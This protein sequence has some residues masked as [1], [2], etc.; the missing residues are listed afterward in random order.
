MPLILVLTSCGGNQSN[1]GNNAGNSANVST[2]NASSAPSQELAQNVTT[3]VMQVPNPWVFFPNTLKLENKAYAGNAEI[4]FSTFVNVSSLPKGAIGK[5]M[6]VVYSTLLEA[7]TAISYLQK[8]YGYAGTIVELYQTFIN[9]NPNNYKTFEKTTDNFTFKIV[10]DDQ[11]YK[12]YVSYQSVAIE[13][14]YEITTAKCYGRIQLTN[15]NV[16]KYE[17]SNNKLTIAVNIFNVSLNELHFERNGN[18]ITGYL[19]EFLGTE[20]HNLKTSAFIKIDEN[21]TT[22]ISN[23]RETDDLLI[24]GYMEVYKNSTGNL[25][26]AE[27]KETVKGADYDTK[28]FNLWDVSN[29]NTIKVLDDVNGLNADTIFI[30]GSDTAIKTKLVGGLSL[31]ATSRR[32]DIEMKDVFVYTYN[33]ETQK[34]VKTKISLPMLFVQAEFVDSFSADFYSKNDETGAINPTTINLNATDN[35]YISNQYAVLIDAYAALKEQ[36]TYQSILNYIGTRDVYFN[37]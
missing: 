32:F 11:Y 17:I 28:W 15:S 4:D 10:L 6:N 14:S 37:A 23:K 7:E 8:V 3:D 29:I 16:I 20:A 9:D 31:K 36:V 25:V 35:T 24:E 13:L 27:V 1:S 12:M 22:I 5:Q 26:G 2:M 34:Y 19:Y 33:A 21:Y 18:V 30:N